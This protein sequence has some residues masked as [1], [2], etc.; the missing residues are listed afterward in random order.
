MDDELI[1]QSARSRA[2]F[3][4]FKQRQDLR[5]QIPALRH[6]FQQRRVLEM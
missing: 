2:A 1:T 4:Q 6:L 5:N 3:P